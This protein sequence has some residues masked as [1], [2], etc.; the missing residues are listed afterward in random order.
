M[1]KDGSAAMSSTRGSWQPAAWPAVVSAGTV[2]LAVA[3]GGGSPARYARYAKRTVRLVD[4]HIASDT[5]G[6]TAGAGERPGAG[7]RP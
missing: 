4:G 6:S 3:C 2:Q 7:A 1:M 5:A